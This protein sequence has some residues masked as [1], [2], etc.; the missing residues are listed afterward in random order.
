MAESKELLFEIEDNVGIITLNRPDKLNPI[1]WELGQQLCDLFQELRERDEV[2]AI[3]LAGAGR[4]FS[5]D[6]LPVCQ[7]GGHEKTQFPDRRGCRRDLLRWRGGDAGRHAHGTDRRRHM[8]DRPD[9]QGQEPF[10][11]WPGGWHLPWARWK[12]KVLPARRK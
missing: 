9:G 10:S 4:A 8:V 11:A 7:G 1:D 2:R 12:K 6:A 5:A 3:V